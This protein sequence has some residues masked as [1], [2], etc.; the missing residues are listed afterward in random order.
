MA[1]MHKMKSAVLI[2]GVKLEKGVVVKEDHA[3]FKALKAGGHFDVI[4]DEPESKEEAPSEK[5]SA[6]KKPSKE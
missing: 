2:D 6:N 4:S 1:K 3:S 5:P